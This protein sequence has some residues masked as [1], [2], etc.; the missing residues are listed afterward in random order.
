MTYNIIP[1]ALTG[2]GE[3]TNLSNVIDNNNSTYAVHDGT[4][5][6]TF[7]MN[8]FYDIE[9][10]D[11]ENLGNPENTIDYIAVTLRMTSVSTNV[12]YIIGLYDGVNI[13]QEQTLTVETTGTTY[14]LYFMRR[15]DNT[16]YRRSDIRNNVNFTL[17]VTPAATGTV[18]NFYEVDVDVELT[19]SDYM[20]GETSTYPL[21]TDTF[22]A[23]TNATSEV[24]YNTNYI[25]QSDQLNR[26]GDSIVTT[27]R[28]LN[29]DQDILRTMGAG[30]LTFGKDSQGASDIYITN[31]VLRG[32]QMNE[33]FGLYYHEEGLS[34]IHDYD[35]TD[36][37]AGQSNTKTETL[38]ASIVSEL[39]FPL[40]S[41]MGWVDNGGTRYP[42]LVSPQVMG[43]VSNSPTVVSYSIGFRAY[44]ALAGTFSEGFSST[45][46]PQY[47]VYTDA[48]SAYSSTG[49]TFEVRI[50]A[51][52]KVI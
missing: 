31:Y 51:I 28:L 8:E 36:I 23:V 24:T 26:L 16:S 1:A 29:L 27:Q 25:I 11:N 4:G 50:L 15:D 21:G 35:Y 46:T 22:A 32:T 52:G 17:R 3:W 39:Q 47:D 2:S 19:E 5:T 12:D 41:G 30:L 43:F 49:S 37:H 18:V 42:L 20:Q 48:A 38:D 33:Y 45:T 6:T 9:D 10:S 14:T 13:D 7:A 44:P 34:P 40:V